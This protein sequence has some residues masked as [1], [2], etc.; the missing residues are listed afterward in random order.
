[1]S[2]KPYARTQLAEV[3]KPQSPFI[4]SFPLMAKEV[5]NGSSTSFQHMV[6]PFV[7]DE[8][9]SGLVSSKAEDEPVAQD[10]VQTLANLYSE[11]FNEAIYGLV[12]EAGRF[13][14][15][16]VLA[17]TP[18]LVANE[19]Q[20]D[21]LLEDHFSP[22]IKQS[23]AALDHMAYEL[24]RYDTLSMS[25]VEL[26]NLLQ[27]LTPPPGQLSPAFEAFFGGL[28][29]KAKQAVTAA[30][31]NVANMVDKGIQAGIKLLPKNVLNEI[32]K[33]VRPLIQKVLKMARNK[34]P[35]T[36]QQPMRQL[37]R[38]FLKMEV[39]A[40]EETAATT[41]SEAATYDVRELQFE[42]DD[43]VA[44][45]LFTPGE[46]EHQAALEGFVNEV[47][48]AIQPSPKESIEQARIRFAQ[49]ISQLPPGAD[50]TP[51]VEEFTGAVMLG[52]KA[53]KTAVNLIGK[54]NVA[55]TLAGLIAPL[56]SKF[57]GQQGAEALA[58]FIANTGLTLLDTV[59]EVGT[60]PGAD[61][62]AMTVEDTVK[63]VMQYPSYVFEDREL[64]QG[65]VMQAFETAIGANFPAAL[66][67][68]ELR[69]V[70][71]GDGAWVLHPRNGQKNYKK[72]TRIFDVTIPAQKAQAIIS[73]GGVSLARFLRDQ[74]GLSLDQPI[75]ARVHLYEAIRG[76]WLSRISDGEKG[77][78]G[79]GTIKE[80]SWGQ[81]HPLTPE[82]AAA[83]LGEP[84]LGRQVDSSYLQSRHRIAVGQRF[85]FLEIPHAH[86][87]SQPENRS[88]RIDLVLNFIA[89][90]ISLALFISEAESQEIAGMLERGN[91]IGASTKVANTVEKDLDSLPIA[92]MG[93]RVKLIYEANP[94][95]YLDHFVQG[96]AAAAAKALLKSF[97]E[98]F[99]K[100]LVRVAVKSLAIF[101]RERIQEV[102]RAAHDPADG[103]TLLLTIN[104][105]PGFAQAIL[106]LK[107]IKGHASDI[108]VG[109]VLRLGRLPTP[110]VEIYPGYRHA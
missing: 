55:K 35:P 70:G 42:F 3:W 4:D 51:V 100:E 74:L 105:P 26:D 63:E 19:A 24:E 87:G 14:E 60:N 78:P 110:S 101:V 80:R 13:Y 39:N 88:S 15:E 73:F 98:E 67:K 59:G 62:L 77:V 6:S 33:F 94:E 12:Y 27:Q 46:S 8:F 53:V 61:A 54:E 29:D 47:A 82:A 95:L 37:A 68:P 34:I 5:M 2:N 23:E 16:R 91:Y 85:F 48:Q 25:E 109:N 38:H 90:K 36:F 66:L 45:Y 9:K 40:A 20:V 50:P 96:A 81:I 75:R 93:E 43:L 41:A 83:L 11:E 89:P 44:H 99:K 7:A 22:L 1:M 84:S 31:K 28:I 49:Q 79:L 64:L 18:H 72:H 32:K 21:F 52:L 103:M 17:N 10:F 30:V 57:V 76:T 86:L 58:S 69:E 104:N 107:L 106:F 108:S 71:E 65:Y 56:I 97:L 102:V 92:E